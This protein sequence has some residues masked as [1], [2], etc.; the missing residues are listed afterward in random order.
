[1]CATKL[2]VGGTGLKTRSGSYA[3]L[4][5]SVYHCWSYRRLHRVGHL[6]NSV[7][8]AMTNALALTSIAVGTG[9][10]RS[11]ERMPRAGVLWNWLHISQ[12]DRA[13]P[14]DGSVARQKCALL[15]VNGLHSDLEQSE[16]MGRDGR[17]AKN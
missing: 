12:P 7:D 6:Y 9:G 8:M 11:Q 4:A 2:T 13:T 3:R 10:S 16:R 14:R 17:L 1:M 15:Q 5:R